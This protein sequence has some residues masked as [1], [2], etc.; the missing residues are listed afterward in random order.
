MK[1]YLAFDLEISKP[2][3]DGATDWKA[4]RPLGISCAATLA[5]DAGGV[6]LWHGDDDGGYAP[7]M[8]KDEAV[9]LLSH[10]WHSAVNEGY[11]ILT[12][13]GLSFDFDVLAEESGMRAECANLALNHHVDTM[14]HFFCLKGHFIGLDKIAKGAGL[15]GKTEGMNG[16]LAPQMWAEGKYSEVLEYVAQDVRTTLDVALA[17]EQQKRVAWTARS[18]RFNSVALKNWLTVSEAMRLPEPDTSWMSDP[19]SRA[20]FVEWT[21]Q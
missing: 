2:L 6:M 19:V 10:L 14:F 16:A 4:H 21:Q 18:G 5:S 9:D 15:T 13:N 7:Q 3:P 11:T 12:H 20:Q 8:N 1:K 17:V